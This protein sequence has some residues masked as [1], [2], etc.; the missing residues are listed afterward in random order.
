MRYSETIPYFSAQLPQQHTCRGCGTEFGSICRTV[1]Y[2]GD[3]RKQQVRRA[4]ERH[5]PKRRKQQ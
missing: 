3:C 1:K 5:N 4:N 2:C